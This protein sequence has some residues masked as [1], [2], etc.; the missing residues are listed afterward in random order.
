MAVSLVNGGRGG[1]LACM[2]VIDTPLVAQDV[3]MGLPL[4]LLKRR[5]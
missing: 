1:L 2:V 3:D 5:S 4:H